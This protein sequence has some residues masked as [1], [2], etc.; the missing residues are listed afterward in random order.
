[1]NDKI[2]IILKNENGTYSF[3]SIS[4]IINNQ[5]AI[6]VANSD[7][8]S[9]LDGKSISIKADNIDTSKDVQL[10]FNQK[11]IY[12][13]A[14]KNGMSEEEARNAIKDIIN[15]IANSISSIDTKELDGVVSFSINVDGKIDEK[16]KDK[17]EKSD[18]KIDI[19]S[20]N[21]G[22]VIEEIKKDVIGQ[23]EAVKTIVLNMYNNQL[24][25]EKYADKDDIIE[26]QKVSILLDG[27]TG[28]GKTLIMKEVAKKMN[29]PIVITPATMYATT[30]YKGV[31]LQNML[32]SL[33]KETDGNLEA[34]E[35][36]IVVIDEIDK[37]GKDS[38]QES[39]LEIR[40]AVQQDLLTYIGGSKYTVEYKGKSYDFDTS[41]ITFICLGAFTDM[42]EKKEENLDENGNY[43]ITE[44]DY[45]SAGLMREL[46]GRFSLITSTKSLT[47]EDYKKIL[48]ESAISPLLNLVEL[49]KTIYNANIVYDEEIIDMIATQALQ[50]N[51]GAR[52]IKSVVNGLKNMLL[53]QLDESRKTEEMTEIRITPEMIDRLRFQYV[54]KANEL[55]INSSKKETAKIIEFPTTQYIEE[56][57]K[58]GVKVA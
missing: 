29:L 39:S 6:E 53:E 5:N 22:D 38:D 10:I 33:L 9:L 58:H 17:N 12:E 32:V 15:K 47:K 14:I 7:Y 56:D 28:T 49:G 57:N 8:N 27:P 20:I 54:R 42:R 21:P 4:E 11:A 31:E 2:A 34:A 45:I 44:D 48:K 30:G 46:V 50:K 23:D 25:Y 19:S 52:S 41:K 24:L 13:T 40:K 55:K 35:R 37:L 1:M 18:Y 26:S 16:P 51:T 3:D 43:E 36:G